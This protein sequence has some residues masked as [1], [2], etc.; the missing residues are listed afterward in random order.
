MA[1]I[2]QNSPPW[3]TASSA[4]FTV[5]RISISEHLFDALSSIRYNSENARA[6][7]RKPTSDS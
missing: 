7:Y 2:V 4:A 3:C 5:D 6:D 1:A